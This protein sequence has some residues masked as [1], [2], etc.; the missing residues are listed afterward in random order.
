MKCF[1]TLICVTSS[2][3]VV[4]YKTT[5]F[6]VDALTTELDNLDSLEQGLHCLCWIM[7][8]KLP[9][10]KRSVVDWA[11]FEEGAN[12]NVFTKPKN[13]AWRKQKQKPAG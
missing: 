12:G 4:I 13:V 1:F 7:L 10:N 11:L 8:K 5:F 3:A 2:R 6:K 9:P